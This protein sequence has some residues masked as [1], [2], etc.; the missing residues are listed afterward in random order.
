MSTVT[1]A[2]IFDRVIDPSNPTLT[3]EAAK[4]ILNLGYCESDHIR[5][6]ELAAKSN[7]GTLTPEEKRELESYVFVGDVMAMM[8]SKARRV[9]NAP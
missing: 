7:E 8:K 3:P 5:M 9:A 1:A 6:A 2:D 4:A